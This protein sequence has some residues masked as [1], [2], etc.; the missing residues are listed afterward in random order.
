MNITDH[1]FEKPKSLGSQGVLP[2]S[3]QFKSGFL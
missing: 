3:L 1:V 2:I